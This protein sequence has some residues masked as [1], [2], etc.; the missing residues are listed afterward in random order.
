VPVTF[1]HP[2]VVLPLRRWLPFAAMAMGAMAP[3]FL[4]FLPLDNSVNYK[5]G[6]EWPGVVT[7]S[8][9]A[10]IV[11]WLLWKLVLRDGVVALLPNSE[12]QKLMLDDSSFAWNSIKSWLVI[13]IAT[14]IGV[15]SHVALDSFSH[16]EGWG[17]EHVSFLTT[18]PVE[19]ANR[20]LAVYKLVQYFGSIIGMGIL[21]IAYWFWSST[22]KRDVLYR[23]VLP[24]SLREAVWIAMT[25]IAMVV[26]Y[27]Y[28]LPA[29]G[30]ASKV[31]E[32]IIGATQVIFLGVLVIGVAV[33]MARES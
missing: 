7:F 25:F 5:Y 1:A 13:V 9:P 18:V 10:A 11:M 3:D 23:P 17:V 14:V 20:E 15:L 4:Y 28:T 19:I 12:Q 31:G 22:A 24:R 16:K 26:G 30:L 21:L 33:K 29:S 27:R 32:A 8:V 6:H 2:V